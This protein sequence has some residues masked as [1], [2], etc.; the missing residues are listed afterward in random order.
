MQG[1]H[2]RL[3]HLPEQ[4][5]GALSALAPLT[6]LAAMTLALG[7]LLVSDVR[8]LVLVLLPVAEA[9]SL[10]TFPLPLGFL[11]AVPN[12]GAGGRDD[13]FGKGGRDAAV[14]K[15]DTPEGVA[16]VDDNGEVD[17]AS[18]D[19]PE[20]LEQEPADAE[21]EREPQSFHDAYESESE[22]SSKSAHTT[23]VSER[24]FDMMG[25]SWTVLAL[26]TLNCVGNNWAAGHGLETKWLRMGKSDDAYNGNV[27]PR[28]MLNSDFTQHLRLTIYTIEVQ[29]DRRVELF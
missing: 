7:A 22:S 13:A 28:L 8:S 12:G 6:A 5:D 27:F 24:R 9:L 16:G 20:P 21:R 17:A 4:F 19:T 15:G 11:A 14:S 3:V 23:P 2:C 25:P 10:I 18:V 29:I 1:V 26:R